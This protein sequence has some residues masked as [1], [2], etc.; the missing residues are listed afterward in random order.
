MIED[1]IALYVKKVVSKPEKIQVTK[2]ELDTNFYEIE[3]ISSEQDIGRLIG[4][5]GKMIGAIKT[6]ISGSK[7]K[8]GNSYRVIVKT[9]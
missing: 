3:I 2:K 8:D 1:F 7:A 6:I 9:E 5:D 4:K